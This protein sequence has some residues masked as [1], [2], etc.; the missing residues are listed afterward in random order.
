MLNHPNAWLRLH[1][2]RHLTSYVHVF[3]SAVVIVGQSVLISLCFNQCRL[4]HPYRTQSFV[5]SSSV[6]VILHSWPYGAKQCG[7]LLGKCCLRSLA[8]APWN[9]LRHV[10][11]PSASRLYIGDQSSVAYCLKTPILDSML[12]RIWKD[13]GTRDCFSVRWSSVCIRM[14]RPVG[15]EELSLTSPLI[16]SILTVQLVR[17]PQLVYK[18]MEL[19]QGRLVVIGWLG[20][21]IPNV[22]FNCINLDRLSSPTSL[23]HLAAHPLLKVGKKRQ[24]SDAVVKCINLFWLG[25]CFSSAHPRDIHKT[26]ALS[27]TRKD[28]PRMSLLTAPTSFR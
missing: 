19:V 16:A 21:T 24:S 8:W 7:I 23:T 25:W 2:T 4:P 15:W 28:N 10:E 20:R 5:L 9:W 26:L 1:S 22:V 17:S 3:L 18:S 11:L 14:V 13:W 12:N 6:V 27:V